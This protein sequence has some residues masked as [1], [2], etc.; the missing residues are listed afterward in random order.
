MGCRTVSL[1]VRKCTPPNKVHG[2]YRHR[3]QRSS[4]RGAGSHRKAAKAFTL[5]F[6]LPS[7]E[8]RVPL[9]LILTSY[10][11][12]PRNMRRMRLTSHPAVAKAFGMVRAPV[13]TMRLNM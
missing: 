13:P 10:L 9:R 2:Q 5:S 7:T 11:I 1:L 6:Q 8:P 3:D 4:G 12:N